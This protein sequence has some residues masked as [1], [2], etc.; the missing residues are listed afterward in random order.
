MRTLA[1]L[2]LTAVLAAGC[3]EPADAP[4]DPPPDAAATPVPPRPT[5]DDLPAGVPPRVAYVDHGAYVDRSG[6]RSPLPGRN[7]ISGAVPYDG[8]FL[9]SDARWFEMSNGLAFVR[10][11]RPVPG[12][13]PDR[14]C[15]SGTPADDGGFVAWAAVSCPESGYTVP[16]HLHRSAT[17]G[18][19]EVT[20]PVAGLASVVGLLGSRVVYH[21]HHPGGAWVTDFVDPPVRVRGIDGA[22]DVDA[23]HQRVIGW[24][25]DRARVVALD[26]TLLWRYPRGSLES[27]SPR[28]TRVLARRTGRLVVLDADDGSVAASLRLPFRQVLQLGWED[29]RHVLAV[30]TRAGRTAVLRLG[31]DGSVERATRPAPYRPTGPPYVLLD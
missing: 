7:G 6:H 2:L 31:I 12:W 16:G 23:A 13:F 30:V 1:A 15:S 21:Q 14:L 10:D 18:S 20:Q 8:G 9:V 5:L 29:E 17:D 27:F 19:G 22:A 24:R 26:G 11:G 25:G 4:A 3:S 28:G